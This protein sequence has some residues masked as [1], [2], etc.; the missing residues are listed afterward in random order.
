MQQRLLDFVGTV[1]LAAYDAVDLMLGM[2]DNLIGGVVD[3][4]MLVVP[5]SIGTGNNYLVRQYLQIYVI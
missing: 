3:A 1:T 2:S 4:Y 5:Y